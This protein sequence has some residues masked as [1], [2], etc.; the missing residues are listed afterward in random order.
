MVG[1]IQKLLLDM[2]ESANGPEGVRELKRRAGV[3]EDQIYRMDEVY[4]DEECMRLLAAACE[5]LQVSQ[6]EA[7]VAYADFFFN[8]A[9]K[10]W[11]MWFKMS[12]NSREFLQRQP[13]IHNG[14]ATS[15]EDLELRKGIN[16][17]FSMVGTE[18]SLVVTYRSPNQ[19]CGLFKTLAQWI[20]DY[21]E[22]EAT[23]EEKSCMKNGDPECEIHIHWHTGPG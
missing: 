9:K 11:P 13:A 10:R 20:I 8:D 18:S 14:F 6:A 17:K 2:V 3:P 21:Y 12:K 4:S 19:L 5:V 7:E 16:D 1:L 23:F 22:D 15:F